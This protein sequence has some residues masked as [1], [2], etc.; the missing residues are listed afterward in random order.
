MMPA[1]KTNAQMRSTCDEL[2]SEYAVYPMARESWLSPDGTGPNSAPGFLPESNV[3]PKPNYV[4]GHGGRK[5]TGYYHI[6]TRNSYQILNHRLQSQAPISC[7]CLGTSK[8]EYDAWDTTARIVYN[9]S[10]ASKPDDVLAAKEAIA[11]A[12]KTAQ[13]VYNDS[14]NLQLAVMIVF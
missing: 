2:L 3:G 7:C 1:N 9:R 8:A 13:A 4:Y 12:Q 6:L 5:G 11:I 14:Q 10:V